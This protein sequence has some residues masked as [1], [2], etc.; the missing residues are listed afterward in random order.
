MKI[1]FHVSISG[2]I[3]KSV[4]RAKELEINTFQIFTRNPRMWKARELRTE[5]IE[6]FRDNALKFDISPVFSHMPY[7]PNLATPVD[8]IY[9]KSKKALETEI[10]NCNQL[11]IPYIVT[12]LGSHLGSGSDAGIKRVTEAINEVTDK[13]SNIPIILLEN[14]SGKT[15]EIGSTFEE[16]SIIM[17]GLNIENG[18]CLDTCH[19]F[20]QGYDI[21]SKK[22]LDQVLNQFEKYI[23]WKKLRLIHLN[24]SRG[25]MGSKIDRHQHIGLGEIGEEGFTNILNSRIGSKPIIMETPVDEVRKDIDNLRKVRELL[26][27]SK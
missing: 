15:N 2:G 23:G 22:G 27:M 7:L 14:T 24:D 10:N 12:H 13:F 8:E 18:I 6:N 25:E 16:L 3:D 5:E 26:D 20:T 11:E 17:D 19:A 9:E 1:G 21:K 4:I